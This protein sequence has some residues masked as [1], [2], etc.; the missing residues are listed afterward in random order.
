MQDF[1]FIFHVIV[2]VEGVGGAAGPDDES[3]PPPPFEFRADHPF[4][5]Y[6]WDNNSKS[7]IFAGRVTNFK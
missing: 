2:A 3:T 4:M 5:Y 6:I 1:F 7:T